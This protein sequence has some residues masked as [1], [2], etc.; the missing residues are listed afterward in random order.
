M[1]IKINSGEFSG[2]CIDNHIYPWRDKKILEELYVERELST[3]EISNKFGCSPTTICY[4]MEKYGIDRRESGEAGRQANRVERASYSQIGGYE[5]WQVREPDG[6][7]TVG[8]SQLTAIA[9]GAE[10][11][12]VFANDTH[13]HHRNKIPFDNRVDNIEVVSVSQHS[14]TH[15]QAA[16]EYS[17]NLGCQVLVTAK[18]AEAGDSDE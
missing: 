6:N 8:V 1:S 13:I 18:A 11:S 15:D 4:W 5:C 9:D 3:C 16:Y 17:E 7:V 2:R 14:E 10:P 12:E